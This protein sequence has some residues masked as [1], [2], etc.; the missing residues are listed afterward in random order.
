MLSWH[1]E[2]ILTKALLVKCRNNTGPVRSQRRWAIMAVRLIVR[3]KEY[4]VSASKFLDKSEKS[5]VECLAAVLDLLHTFEVYSEP[6]SVGTVFHLHKGDRKRLNQFALK[7]DHPEF[8][9]MLAAMGA[10]FNLPNENPAD[11]FHPVTVDPTVY[12]KVYDTVSEM[13]DGQ[14]FFP[15]RRQVTAEAFSKLHCF[16]LEN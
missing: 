14:T 4:N 5:D 2:A 13:A 11:V 3:E 15:T 7:G 16:L 8:A 12:I 6:T 1:F 10:V 9:S